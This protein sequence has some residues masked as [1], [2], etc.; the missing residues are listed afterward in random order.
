MPWVFTDYLIPQINS[1]FNIDHYQGYSNQ[2]FS[3]IA[4]H[5]RFYGALPQ[6][7]FYKT[8]PQPTL[9]EFT[10]DG[11]KKTLEFNMITLREQIKLKM[12]HKFIKLNH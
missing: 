2:V 5:Q 11:E 7:A 4:V 3:E 12:Y 1:P 6:N 10:H 9:W 8:R